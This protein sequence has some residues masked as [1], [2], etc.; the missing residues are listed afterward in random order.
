VASSSSASATLQT[1][2]GEVKW[3]R[4]QVPTTTSAAS[5]PSPSARNQATSDAGM[6]VSRRALGWTATRRK[7]PLMWKPTAA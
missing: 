3:R 2:F 4:N 7:N 1:G 5:H 6:P